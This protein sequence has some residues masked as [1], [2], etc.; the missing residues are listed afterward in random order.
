[1]TNEL[2]TLQALEA[3]IEESNRWE[4]PIPFGD[5][6]MAFNPEWLPSPLSEYVSAV[7]E[8][9]QVPVDMPAVGV[10]SVLGLCNSRNYVVQVNQDYFE[11]L[12]LYSVIVAEPS[13]RKSSVLREITGPVVAYEEEENKRLASEI[14]KSVQEKKLLQKELL[15]LE[16]KASKG[17]IPKEEALQKAVE[18]SEHEEV[19]PLRLIADDVTMEKLTSLL[20]ENKGKLGIFSGEGQIFSTFAGQ[21]SKK[22]NFDV[23]LKAFTGEDLRVDRLGRPSEY[24]KNPA[25]TML[26]A[27]QPSVLEEVVGNKNFQGRGLISRILF[28]I[29]VSRIGTRLFESAPIP[30]ALKSRYDKLVRRLLSVENEK[31][32][33]L[34]LSSGGKM[35]L[36]RFFNEI[37]KRLIGDL[38]ELRAF[39]GKV[40]GLM[41]RI[42]GN[43]HCVKY[44]DSPA[45]QLIEAG[46][47]KSAIEICRYA[48][49][50]ASIAMAV[51]RDSSAEGCNYILRC[52]KKNGKV[53]A[54]TKRDLLRLCRRFKT[55]EQLSPY[56]EK[57]VEHGFLVLEEWE[58]S[59]PGRPSEN[60]FVNPFIFEEGKPKQTRPEEAFF[61][62]GVITL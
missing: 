22:E 14:V 31:A 36:E 38:Y 50:H 2:N 15:F 19:T 30:E 44:P 16:D 27:I 29:P 40:V 34:K 54:I 62:G 6:P 25:L 26:L 17:S 23:I 51:S 53:E 39:G 11:P 1:M 18:L 21:Y 9:I 5:R 47:I 28:S 7:A 58:Q 12:N 57:L 3:E 10:L 52:I 4:K 59:G 42:V 56:L 32:V 33:P 37:E 45:S 60:Y 24:V 55:E 13:E 20:H 49:N 43:L 48:L 35:E 61:R 41:V 8:S 46:T